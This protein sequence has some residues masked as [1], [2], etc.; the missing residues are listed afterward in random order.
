[1]KRFLLAL[2][3]MVYVVA[4]ASYADDKVSWTGPGWYLAQSAA[5]SAV[6]LLG[7]AELI[8]GPYPTEGACNKAKPQDASGLTYSCVNADAPDFAVRTAPQKPK[9][10]K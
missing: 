9:P 2:G 3:A 6:V 10:S 4:N 5:E 1:M 8:G 7:S